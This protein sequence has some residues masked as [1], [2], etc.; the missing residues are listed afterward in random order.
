VGLY[1]LAFVARCVLV[2]VQETGLGQDEVTWPAEPIQDW[3]G[4]AVLFVELLG[5][6]LLPA[7]LI[8][9]ML[10]HVWLPDE[11]MLRILLLAGP[12]LWLFF[13]IV[14]LSSLS[15]SSRWVPFR[16][17][18]F[19]QFLRIAPAAV[20]FYVL[21]ALLLAVGVAPWYFALVKHQTILLPVAAVVS[22]AVV[23]IYARLIGRVAWLIQRL[24]SRQRVVAKP[25]VEKHPPIKS[26]GKKKRKPAIKAQDPWAV[27][28]EAPSRAKPKRFPWAEEKPAKAKSAYTPPN[29]EDIEGYGIAAEQSIVPDAPA[30][31]P[32]KHPMYTSPE[33]YEPID[34]QV[35][36]EVETPSREEPDSLFTQQVQQRI[37]ERE[38]AEPP[39]PPHPFF[40]GVYTFPLYLHCLPNWILLALGGLVLGGIA[41][42]LIDLGG[43]LFHE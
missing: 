37:A 10:R 11:G 34:M 35:V 20:G 31:K 42:G 7:G 13:P 17:T 36:S 3:L 32:A 41:F 1:V 26:H 16:W 22:A 33:E 2:V 21:T 6:W 19:C 12:G 23:L 40:S 4:H 27:P 29:A 39:A 14:L 28:E 18:I 8:A 24:P 15:A 25:P 38:R 43:S 9:R 30:E 5:L